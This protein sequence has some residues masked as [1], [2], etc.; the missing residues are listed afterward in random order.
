MKTNKTIALITGVSREEGIGFGL[1]KEMTSRGFEV[2]I[3][4]RDL[5]KAEALAK[6]I[7]TDGNNVVAEA[8]DVTNDA[9]AQKLAEF[10]KARYGRLDVLINNAGGNLDYMVTPL[11][12]DFENAK[13]AF[14]TN[15]FGAWRVIKHMHPL[16]KASLHPRVVNISSGAGSFAHPIFGLSVH[17]AMLT[18]Y[19][20]SKLAL[21]GLTMQLARELKPDGVLVNA[22]NPGFVATAPGMEAMGARSV[23]DSVDSII[24]AA[25][26]PDDGPTGHFFEDKKV[27]NW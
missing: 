5:T 9:S 25:T 1:A 2:I 23:A 27:I 24:W 13:Q 18:S 19:G 7:S 17:P 16:L 10:I 22:V 11:A 6:K 12:T 20:L 14:E 4:A 8:L 3:A 21:N 15:L 26:L